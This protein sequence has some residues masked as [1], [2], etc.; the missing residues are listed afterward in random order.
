VTVKSATPIFRVVKKH[1]QSQ[2][3]RTRFRS[4]WKSQISESETT[5]KM[6]IKWL[7][8]TKWLAIDYISRLTGTTANGVYQRKNAA[9]TQNYTIR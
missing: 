4:S 2:L 5:K 1:Q 8:P 6:K 9:Y 3:Y 7:W